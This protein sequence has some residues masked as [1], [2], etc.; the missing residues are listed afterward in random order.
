MSSSITP[1]TWDDI[2]V[3]IRQS[4][5]TTYGKSASFHYKIVDHMQREGYSNLF[6]PLWSVGRLYL[7]PN[8]NSNDEYVLVYPPLK[9][10]GSVRIELLRGTGAETAEIEMIE[11]PEAEAIGVLDG[12]IK[13]LLSQSQ[14]ED[15]GQ[16][17]S[18]P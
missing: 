15:D 11:V 12:Y 4:E 6:S 9:L 2:I 3:S 1:H 7:F 16:K 5:L 8:S 13:H 18:P 14:G 17:V 10:N